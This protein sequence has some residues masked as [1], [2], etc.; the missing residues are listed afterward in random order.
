M[1]KTLVRGL[2][3]GLFAAVA[4]PAGARAQPPAGSASTAKVTAP[5]V[6]TVDAAIKRA[7]DAATT[8][9]AIP[10]NQRTF[11][12]TLGAVDDLVANLESDTSMLIFMSN[13]STDAAVREASQKA[14]EQAGNF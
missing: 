11:D 8:I 2:L 3:V 7:N 4:L 5:P 14:E 9:V 1:S 13:V 12:N 10:D 6:L